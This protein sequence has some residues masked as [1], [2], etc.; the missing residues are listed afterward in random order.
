MLSIAAGGRGYRPSPTRDSRAL[1]P[2]ACPAVGEQMAG[3]ASTT[4]GLGGRPLGAPQARR[5][6]PERG[7][8]FAFASRHL[9]PDRRTVDHLQIAI[10]AEFRHLVDPASGMRLTVETDRLPPPPCRRRHL[11]KRRAGADRH[12]CRRN[13][14]CRSARIMKAT[15]MAAIGAQPTRVTTAGAR[16]HR[17]PPASV[18]GIMTA[19]GAYTRFSNSFS[20]KSPI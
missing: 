10:E 15:G 4:H 3:R 9:R 19:R 6:Q 17:L 5:P 13:R 2:V 7:C 1:R 8:V 11:R 14:P 20:A 12:R 16:R 18:C